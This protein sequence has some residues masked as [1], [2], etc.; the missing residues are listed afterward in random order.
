MKCYICGETGIDREA[1]AVCTGCGSGICLEHS[2]CHEKCRWVGDYP[3]PA[4]KL[5]QKERAIL[6]PTC[7]SFCVDEDHNSS[8]KSDPPAG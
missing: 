2:V 6:C 1:V 3:F 5:E 7:S 8:K 4:R